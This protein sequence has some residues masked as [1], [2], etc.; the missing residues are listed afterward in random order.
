MFGFAGA[1]GIGYKFGLRRT[2]QADSQPTPRDCNLL[3]AVSL[4]FS[5]PYGHKAVCVLCLA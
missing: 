2:A 4:R 3:I 1:L 5:I